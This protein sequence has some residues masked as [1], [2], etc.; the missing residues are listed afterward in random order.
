MTERTGIMLRITTEES[1]SLTTFRLEGKLKGDWVQELERCWTDARALWPET[2]FSIDLD[3]VE[4][5]DES[6]SALL[7]RMV[8][9]GASLEAN[10]NLMMS[11]LVEKIVRS[12]V[13]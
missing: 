11:L 9:Y 5:V 10:S 3:N 8:S 1:Y 12:A 6:G 13:C 4:F 2:Q 7:A